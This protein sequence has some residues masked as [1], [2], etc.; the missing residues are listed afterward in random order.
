MKSG[1][2]KIRKL[3]VGES[4]LFGKYR[5]IRLSLPGYFI[6]WEFQC[7]DGFFVPIKRVKMK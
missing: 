6:Q 3:S 2:P 7:P 5:A 4:I 1:L